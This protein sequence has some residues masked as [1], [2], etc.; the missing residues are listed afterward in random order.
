MLNSISSYL[1]S[2]NYIFKQ[3][4][5]GFVYWLTKSEQDELAAH[6]TRFEVQTAEF[7]A[8]STY[9]KPPSSEGEWKTND[10]IL[11]SMQEMTGAKLSVKKIGEALKK[12]GFERK[13]FTR[14]NRRLWGYKV[15]NQDG[16]KDEDINS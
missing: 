2:I 5:E 14:N 9:L 15:E 11:R 10:Q 12:L 3:F 8:I 4:K 13:Q 16:I 6:N 1:F 7:E